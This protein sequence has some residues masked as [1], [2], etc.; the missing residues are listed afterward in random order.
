MWT[1]FK[2]WLIRKL[3]GFA[4]GYRVSDECKEKVKKAIEKRREKLNK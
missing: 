3:G 4:D 1:K 2:R